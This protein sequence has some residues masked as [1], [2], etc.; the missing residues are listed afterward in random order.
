[1]RKDNPFAGVSFLRSADD[2]LK[3]F[4]KIQQLKNNELTQNQFNKS[5]EIIDRLKITS[6]ICP[7]SR[8]PIP[9]FH[10]P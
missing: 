3:E 10:L 5:K 1:V 4:L 6:F 2:E 8:R 7:G 9:Q